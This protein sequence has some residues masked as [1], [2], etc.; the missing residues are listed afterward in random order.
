MPYTEAI[1][2][3]KYLT[4]ATMPDISFAVGQVSQFCKY[5]GQNN[6]EAVKRTLSFLRGTPNHG[7]RFGPGTDG[8]GLGTSPFPQSSQ[9]T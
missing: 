4:V 5:P 6:W 3:L 2:S 1:G 9:S 8:L 7:I